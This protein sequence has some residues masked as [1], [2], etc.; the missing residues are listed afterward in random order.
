MASRNSVSRHRGGHRTAR[1]TSQPPESAYQV[2]LQSP[3]RG[4]QSYKQQ[5][6][7]KYLSS[8]EF[9]YDATLAP[10]YR[11]HLPEAILM[12]STRAGVGW[13]RIGSELQAEH[14]TL[15]CHSWR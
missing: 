1:K 11:L 10:R 13:M 12:L 9:H 6:A 7:A 14:F 2:F 4:G 8:K 3:D 15:C 5:R